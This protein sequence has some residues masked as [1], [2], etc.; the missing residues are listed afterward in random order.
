M[1]QYIVGDGGMLGMAT[2]LLSASAMAN[3]KLPVEER[4]RRKQANE[5]AR[6]ERIRQAQIIRNV[7]PS[8]EGKLVRGKKDKRNDYKRVWNCLNCWSQHSI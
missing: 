4:E 5:D 7:C 2:A 6:Q 3:A 8:C 1:K